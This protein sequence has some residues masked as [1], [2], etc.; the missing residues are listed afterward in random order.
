M[1]QKILL[2]V[3]WFWAIASQALQVIDE[4]FLSNQAPL[5]PSYRQ[6]LE[7]LVHRDLAE[8]ER[9][10]LQ[11]SQENPKAAAPLLG[12]AEIAYQRQDPKAAE[13]Y[14]KQAATVEPEN[15]HVQT[16]LGRYLSLIGQYEK[17]E[18]TL[19]KAAKQ[20]SKTASAW[21]A[22]G[23]FYATF[24][25]R[26]KE[27]VNAYQE[28]LKIEPNHAGAYYGLGMSY[29]KLGESAKALEN[30]RQAA[31]L[32]AN[33]PLP[34]LAIGQVQAKQGQLDQALTAADQ[35]LKIQPGLASARELR[36]DI[37]AAKGDQAAALREYESL[38]REAPKLAD[39]QVKA[40]M[41][42]Q[43]LG[44]LDKAEQAY[45]AA[46]A[47]NPKHAL[48]YNN[49]AWLAVE[50]QQDLAQAASWA[51]EAVKLAPKVAQF[52]DTLGWVYRAQGKLREA[53]KAL[54]QAAKLAPADAAILHHLEVVQEELGKTAQV[55]ETSQFWFD[56]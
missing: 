55:K 24:V 16:S 50:R 36:G 6:G 8:A 45:R 22:L 33:N 38:L 53:L 35:A 18:A 9:A 10:F 42:Y 25:N 13:R 12:L 2:G 28:A 20:S 40:G 5:P 49:L 11:A 46:I 15:F 19:L 32:E 37:L 54:E 31:R 4:K 41:L 23:D 56:N 26:P 17:A 29:A 14:L 39:V 43:A 27:A 52:H 51:K 34:W 7:A 48:A 21:M 3:L 47:A 44:Q 30:L 1:R